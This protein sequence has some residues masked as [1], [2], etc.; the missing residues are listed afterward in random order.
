MS[1]KLSTAAE[2]EALSGASSKAVSRLTFLFD[3][4]KFTEVGRFVKS[5]DALSGVITAFGYVDGVPVYAFSQDISAKS[6]A[7][8][9]E[10][11][12]K[13]SKLYTLAAETGA[14]VVGVYDSYGADVSDALTSLSAYGELLSKS[15]NVSGVVPN[16]SVVCGVCAGA[17]AMLAVNAD[18]VVVNKDSELSVSPH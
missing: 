14:P 8:T 7:L 1:I 4:G 17:A 18:F 10:G 12:D 3:D 6:G 16:V 9:K 5:G 11:A 15:A 2:L 13:I